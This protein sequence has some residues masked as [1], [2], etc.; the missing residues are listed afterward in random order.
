MSKEFR[1]LNL[2][3]RLYSD[4]NDAKRGESGESTASRHKET[5]GQRDEQDRYQRAT[6][7]ALSRTLNF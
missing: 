6:A 2:S 7:K 3:I 1:R 5:V 4:I